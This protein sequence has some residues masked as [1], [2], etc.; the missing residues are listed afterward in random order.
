MRNLASIQKITALNPIK[1]AQAIEVA[2]ILGWQVVVRKGEFNVGS[3]VV[4]CE[5]DSLLPDIE[6]FEGVKKITSG[7][8]RIR[9]V[10]MRGQVSQGICF[11]IDIV[12]H[13]GLLPEDMIIGQDVTTAMRVTKHEDKLPNE[14][15]G[16]AKGYMP[17]DI[18]K[19]DIYRVQTMQP[20][21][22]KY[23]GII[24]VASEKLDGESI[25]FYLKNDVFG[26]C[27]KEVDY[28][29]S[30]DS[31]HWQ[32]ARKLN[33]ESILRSNQSVNIP[34]NIS[35]QGE[36]VGE[37]I[38]KNKYKIKGKKVFLYN[39]FNIDKH[40]Y[41]DY[42]AFVRVTND[43]KLERVPVINDKL[44]LSNDIN[45]L[46]AL[47]NGKSMLY[48]TKREGIVIVPLVEINDIIGRVILKVISPEFLLKHE[49]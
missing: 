19:S 21:L 37:G 8:M 29:E 20:V 35:M 3:A 17:S 42:D 45:D 39:I 1:D 11:P 23:Q 13:F 30:S 43:L 14:L 44:V 10:R 15:L 46:V 33:I 48:D 41:L 26:V 9:T 34:K 27:S 40:R 4:Y 24:C 31:I 6:L 28:L 18:P 36:I 16:A 47:S 22:D 38:K 49:E 25:T 5:I 32:M 2:T 7:T 12:E